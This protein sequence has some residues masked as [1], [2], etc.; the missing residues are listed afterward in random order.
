[1]G[2]RLTVNQMTLSKWVRFPLFSFLFRLFFLSKKETLFDLNNRYFNSYKQYYLNNLLTINNCDCFPYIYLTPLSV[3]K[4]SNWFYIN[5]NQTLILNLKEY[6]HGSHWDWLNNNNYGLTK[7]TLINW[8]YLFF[9]KRLHGNNPEFATPVWKN[10]LHS[11]FFMNH[12]KPYEMRI[13]FHKYLFKEILNYNYNYYNTYALIWLCVDKQEILNFL[14]YRNYFLIHHFWVQYLWKTKSVFPLKSQSVFFW[15][16]SY[17]WY[18]LRIKYKMNFLLDPINVAHGPDNIIIDKFLK[19]SYKYFFYPYFG[20]WFDFYFKPVFTFFYHYYF[21]FA[22]DVAFIFKLF[23]L[24]EKTYSVISSHFYFFF[25][26]KTLSA[27]LGVIS[28]SSNFFLYM[29]RLLWK[30]WTDGY[31]PIAFIIYVGWDDFFKDFLK[32]YIYNKFSPITKQL[33]VLLVYNWATGY[34]LFQWLYLALWELYWFRFKIYDFFSTHPVLENFF[35]FV[36]IHF[37]RLVTMW[38]H[39]NRFY[40]EY[41]YLRW[42]RVI[43]FSVVFYNEFKE[44]IK[45]FIFYDY[46]ILSLLYNTFKKYLDLNKEKLL[47]VCIRLKFILSHIFSNLKPFHIHLNILYLVNTIKFFFINYV[48]LIKKLKFNYNW[49]VWVTSFSV[50]CAMFSNIYTLLPS[51]MVLNQI[52]DFCIQYISIYSW[53]EYYNMW[54]LNNYILLPHTNNT[55][56]EVQN[57]KENFDICTDII[58]DRSQVYISSY[59]FVVSW[60]LITALI[61][62]TTGVT[63]Q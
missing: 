9:K 39:F 51:V 28:D 34:V 6:R 35:Y 56:L 33:G 37:R 17:K 53:F 63:V 13:D 45:W 61:L 14:E 24:N 32:S 2:G 8:R 16:I 50:T 59:C 27:Y 44:P 60:I 18:L 31:F 54:P 29:Y 19:L 47:F 42:S 11:L 23:Y 36:Y 20:W 55:I 5:N 3:F 58:T 30:S 41:F 38:L 25:L 40:A 43:Y 7:I 46:Y 48:F 57:I 10:H 22:T 49:L 15:N 26:K 62:S 12:L 21:I 1:M 4:G 52:L